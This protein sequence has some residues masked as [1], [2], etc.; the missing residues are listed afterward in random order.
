MSTTPKTDKKIWRE[1]ALAHQG[2]RCLRDNP[3]ET[4][5][6]QEFHDWKQGFLASRKVFDAGFKAYNQGDPITKNPWDENES[7]ELHASFRNGWR[8]AKAQDD[9]FYDR[10]E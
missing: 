2:G 5:K 3:C 1:G 9:F 4:T 7:P 6:A 8:E 10:D